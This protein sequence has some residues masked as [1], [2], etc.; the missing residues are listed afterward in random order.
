MSHFVSNCLPL[1]NPSSTLPFLVTK[2]VTFTTPRRTRTW[3]MMCLAP[4]APCHVIASC[5]VVRLEEYV[6][7]P[8]I[9]RENPRMYFSIFSFQFTPAQDTS[10]PV[11][12]SDY[13]MPRCHLLSKSKS[14]ALAPSFGFQLLGQYSAVIIAFT[15]LQVATVPPVFADPDLTIHSLSQFFL[16][17]FLQ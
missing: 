11:R 2:L 15:L 13:C 10:K 7:F 8:L 6:T 16:F 5:K 14:K 17:I 1:Q 3:L 12:G 9:P 4:I